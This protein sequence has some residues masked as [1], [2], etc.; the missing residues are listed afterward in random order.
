MRLV[1]AVPGI[2]QLKKEDPTPLTWGNP[3]VEHPSG[4]VDFHRTL[5]LAT[6]LANTFCWKTPADSY[7]VV[8]GSHRMAA[9]AYSHIVDGLPWRELRALVVH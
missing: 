6:S 1:E 9:V 7:L 8:D 4:P 3:V 5:W 2:P